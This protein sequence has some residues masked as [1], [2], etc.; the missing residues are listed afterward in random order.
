MTT[1]SAPFF[2]SFP[3][4][5]RAVL[6]YKSQLYNY[7]IKFSSLLIIFEE[8]PFINVSKKRGLGFDGLFLG[9]GP[10]ISASYPYSSRSKLPMI[11]EIS[12]KLGLCIVASPIGGSRKGAVL[13]L[14][15]KPRSYPSIYIQYIARRFIQQSPDKSKA[16]I[17]NILRV[18]DL[19]QQCSFCIILG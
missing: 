3:V 9:R 17:R 10:T 1:T 19:M 14:S 8:L 2:F 6:Q 16:S 18:D 4:R 11:G 15:R 7:H 5:E 12:N 13:Y